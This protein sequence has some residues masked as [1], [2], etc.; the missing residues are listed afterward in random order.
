MLVFELRICHG[1]FAVPCHFILPGSSNWI[2]AD[3]YCYTIVSKTRLS[4]VSYNLA[5]VNARSR[6]PMLDGIF[7]PV[8]NANAEHNINT[9]VLRP[10]NADDPRAASY[11][12]H[13]LLAVL[14][15]TSHMATSFA[16]CELYKVTHGHTAA[17]HAL[18][19]QNSVW[20]FSRCCRLNAV[21]GFCRRCID[22]GC[23]Q[24]WDPSG[25]DTQCWLD[26][27]II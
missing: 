12:L 26:D 20:P 19:Q 13:L 27:G 9:S 23:R 4:C 3:L 1:K 6:N 5:S 25:P 17:L 7:R 14:S 2:G 24:D 18:K 16:G 22:L 11:L 21:S 15:S 8:C 10:N